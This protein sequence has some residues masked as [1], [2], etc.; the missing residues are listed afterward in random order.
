MPLLSLP[1]VIPH[2]LVLKASL[3]L[4]LSLYLFPPPC[5]PAPSSAYMAE[6]LPIVLSPSPSSSPSR[7]SASDGILR[8]QFSQRVL[9]RGVVTTAV[10]IKLPS[11]QRD[12]QR[13]YEALQTCSDDSPYGCCVRAISLHPSPL[14]L[15]I[16]AFGQDLAAL[17][18]MGMSIHIRKHELVPGILS[19]VETLHSR[20]SLMHG[21]NT[22]PHSLPLPLPHAI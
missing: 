9:G 4:S 21:N 6:D 10:V 5:Q 13:E 20:Y 22:P 3:S 15:V 1:L 19:A 7:L 17:M 2:P 18:G 11:P 16:E 14:Y 8:G 12:L